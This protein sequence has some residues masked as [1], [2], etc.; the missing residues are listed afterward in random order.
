[1]EPVAAQVISSMKRMDKTG[2]IFYRG[3]PLILLPRIYVCTILRYKAAESR[4]VL[5][6]MVWHLSETSPTPSQLLVPLE[7][8]GP[9]QKTNNSNNQYGHYWISTFRAV[10]GLP[11]YVTG[12]LPSLAKFTSSWE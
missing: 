6:E 2:I 4:D 3:T 1:M 7:H 11:V 5:P 9:G 12:K 10:A 8:L